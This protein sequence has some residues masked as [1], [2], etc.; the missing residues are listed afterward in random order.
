[1]IIGFDYIVKIV[2]LFESSFKI[3]QRRS[4]RVYT[5]ILLNTIASSGDC[6]ADA[7]L[8]YTQIQRMTWAS[9][10]KGLN[11]RKILIQL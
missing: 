3:N 10:L 2:C 1:M 7:N 11:K 9:N 5:N 8:L 6:I 4:F